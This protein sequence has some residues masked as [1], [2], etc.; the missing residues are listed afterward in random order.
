MTRPRYLT[1]SRF[2]LAM[3]CPTK[4]YYT[5]KEEYPDKKKTDPFLEALAEGGYQVGE[6]AK[7]YLPQGHDITSLDYE[8]AEEQT[9]ELLKLQNVVIFEPAIRWQNLFIRIDILIKEGNRLNL[10]EVK[11]K[12]FD[13]QKS[14]IGKR[15]GLLSEWKPYLYDVAFQT[16]VLKKAMPAC[17]VNSILR[18]VKKDARCPTDGLNQKFRIVR[19][20]TNR[21]GIK[22]TTALTEEDLKHHLLGSVSVNEYVE[23]ILNGHESTDFAE[24]SFSDKVFQFAH[25]YANDTKIITP[26]GAKCASCEFICSEEEET[27]GY[28]SG[29][30]ECWSNA[31]GWGDDDFRSPNILKLWYFRKKDQYIKSNVIKMTDLNE[32]DIAPKPDNKPGLS[33]S[34]RQWLQV[35]KAQD[36]DFTPYIDFK[37]LANEME[38]WI[39]PLHFIDFETAMVPIPFNKGRH[40]Y[41]GIAFQ[42]SHHTVYEDGSIEHTGQYLNAQRGIFPNYNFTRELK[43]QLDKDNGTIFRYHHHENTYLNK[44]RSEERRVGKECRSRWSPYH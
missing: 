26:L 38:K 12:S 21:K 37:G 41:E 9:N 28:K 29:F 34:Q 18:M 15:G 43:A 8:E 17:T 27:Q 7:Q 39:Y 31:L 19:D 44:I 13:P 35:K 2:K 32:D 20:E 42:F 14:F 40:P 30:K 36:R 4:L 5:R 6:L 25:E 11:S 10:I 33:T 3:E 24:Q 23:M 16:Y 1:K 22:V